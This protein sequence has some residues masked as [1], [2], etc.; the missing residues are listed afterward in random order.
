MDELLK[1]YA[2]KRKDQAG[3]PFEL[4]PATRNLLQTE[5]SRLAK[6]KSTPTPAPKLGF[7]GDVWLR[8]VFGGAICGVLVLIAGVSMRTLSKS[9]VNYQIAQDSSQH[10]PEFATFTAPVPSAP[11][12]A[13]DSLALPSTPLQQGQQASS[14]YG[15]VDSNVKLEERKSPSP[16]KVGESLRTDLGQQLARGGTSEL[17][18]RQRSEAEEIARDKSSDAYNV[19]LS[20]AAKDTSSQ[21]RSDAGS[22]PTALGAEPNGALVRQNSDVNGIALFPQEQ[23]ANNRLFYLGEPAS[24]P[25][26]G[27]QA[28]HAQGSE[29]TLALAPR[30]IRPDQPV[31]TS[32]AREIDLANRDR[33]PAGGIT[34]PPLKGAADEKAVTAI[35]GVPLAVATAQPAKETQEVLL[36]NRQQI[37]AVSF[38]NA[39][40]QRF[41]QMAAPPKNKV[42]AKPSAAD[43][44]LNSFVVEQDGAQLRFIDADGSVYEGALL[45]G[46]TGTVRTPARVASGDKLDDTKKQKAAASRSLNSPKAAALQTAENAQRI[47][48]EA[49]GY[50]NSSFRVTGTNL[51]V[52]QKVVVNGNF[53]LNTNAAASN[54]TI[55]A[56]QPRSG[57]VQNFQNNLMLLQTPNSRIYGNAIVG[58][59]TQVEINA[60]AVAP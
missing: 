43:F 52:N 32:V 29:Q 59:R 28:L 19:R 18:L 1:V 12:L 44:V 50:Q 22:S 53:I 54:N 47:Q 48:P 41:V 40:R 39:A 37:G 2:K 9:S 51:S 3:D 36:Q 10:T 60:T 38:Q 49:A 58:G 45:A 4:H 55:A 15:L 20:L 7:W 42:S 11:E 25:Q 35:S 16:S 5:V 8:L 24:P 17:L 57:G 33:G 31:P 14:R 56:G 13:G 6:R 21:S 46:D 23:A 30:S 27:L 34:V 26:N